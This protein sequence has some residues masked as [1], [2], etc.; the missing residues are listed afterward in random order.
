MTAN[1]KRG[2]TLIELL[3]VMAIIAILTGVILSVFATFIS[4]SRKG[5][6]KVMIAGLVAANSTYDYDW[7]VYVPDVS[8]CNYPV[9]TSNG[10]AGK[11]PKGSESLYYC[12]SNTFKRNPQ[13]A[14][15]EIGPCLKD[16]TSSPYFQASSERHRD[17]T[18]TGMDSYIDP[19]AQ[20]IQYNNIRE[21]GY[22]AQDWKS[23]TDPR[24]GS[25]KTSTADI[26]SFG[27]P[28]G[29]GKEALGLGFP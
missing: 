11:S 25:A 26:F 29:Q 21:A 5:V 4:T 12:L 9:A 8:V 1:Q 22:A 28:R 13:P 2:F 10:Y 24:Q 7:N 20:P 15:N 23:F 14:K 3:V 6:T 27:D 19:W 17:V 16:G 18:G